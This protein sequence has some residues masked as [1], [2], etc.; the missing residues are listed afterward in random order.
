MAFTREIDMKTVQPGTDATYER[1]VAV[2]NQAILDIGMGRY[3]WS[4]FVLAA[5]G[6]FSDVFWKQAVNMIGP[7]VKPEFHVHQIAFLNV[8]KQTGSVLGGLLWPLTADYIG[9]RP[10]FN[11]TLG[12]AA[13]AGLIGAGS[14]NFAALAIMSG[15]IGFAIGGNQYIDSTIF[16]E[17]VPASHQYLLAIATL[18]P[19]I[20]TASAVLIAWPFVTKYSCSRSDVLAGSCVYQ[21]NL[22]WRYSL[23]T[24][25]AFNL[26]MVVARFLFHLKETPK[27]LLGR[28]R[29]EDAVEVIQKV[30]SRNGKETWLKVEDLQRIDTEL[31]QSTPPVLNSPAKTILKRK[32]A[33]FEPS[34]VKALFCTPKMAISTTLILIVWSMVGMSYVL[35]NSF[36][37]FY[38][39]MK[40]SQTG[41]S[42]TD[43]LFRTLV[44]QSVC[45]I[46]G[47]ILSGVASEIK[48]LGR[49]GTGAIASLATGVFVFLFTQADTN[50][51][52]LGFACAISFSFAVVH[53]ILYGYTPELFPAP[54]RGTG[55][56]L[57]GFLHELSSMAATLIAVY[58]GLDNKSIWISAGLIAGA[59]FIFPFMPYETRGRAAS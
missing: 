6:W 18:F 35:F 26:P 41:S 52:V 42:S 30:A 16:I 14:P 2:I 19:N 55:Q 39:Q 46:P 13:I 57:V 47:A 31:T 58:V 10:A 33:K 20:G 37:P 49:K 15:V 38:L 50:E 53:G 45:G 40:G 56:G 32:L 4:V 25:G 8:A 44:I 34:K 48:I 28:E 1:K 24:Y 29:D 43:T 21:N 7:F 17:F 3:Q 22:G 54:I 5:F 36:L 9:R 27:Y 51:A 23:W 59:G 11:I 12:L